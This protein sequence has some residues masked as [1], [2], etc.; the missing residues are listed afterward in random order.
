MKLATALL[1]LASPSLAQQRAAPVLFQEDAAA[2]TAAQTS[3]LA[4]MLRQARPFTLEPAAVRAALATAPLE[5]AAGASGP[6]VVLA[7]PLPDGRTAR[8]ALRQTAVMA[9][10][11][12]ARYPAI[13]TYSGAGLDDATASL[14][15]S[16][17]P[18]GLHAQVLSATAGPVYIDPANLSDATHYLSYAV[19]ERRITA[20]LP[21]CAAPAA[22][23]AGAPLNRPA[24]AA[25]SEPGTAARSSGPQLHVLRLA[26]ATTDEYTAARGNT[27]A[28]ALAG[29]VT[30][31]NRVSG[32]Y[33]RELGIRLE[34]VA[35][36]DQLIAANTPGAPDTFSNNNAIP[37]AW[38]ENQ[39]LLDRIVGTAG[40]DIGHVFGTYGG[41]YAQISS[42]CDPDFKAQG[43]SGLSSPVGDGFDIQFVAHEMGHQLG[44]TH[45]FNADNA[46]SCTAL[47][48]A[49]ST[50][51]EPGS[52]STMMA[53]PGTCGSENLQ[54]SRDAYF[55]GASYAQIQAKLEYDACGRTLPT[56]NSAPVV[57]TGSL[58]KKVPIGTPF[59]LTAYASDA[60]NDALLYNWE[61]MDAGAAVSLTA[62]QTTNARWPLF[63]SYPASSSATRYF[64]RLSTLL[65]NGNDVAERL[66]SVTRTLTF[67]CLVRDLHN[68]TQ[69]VVGGAAQTSG[70]PLSFTAA[71]GPFVVTAP[72]TAVSWP[73]SST[74]TV[75]WNVAGTDANGVDCARVNIRLS[76]DGGLTYPHL[77]LASTPND[78]TQTILVPNVPGP[79]A[80]LLVE[81]ADNVFFD[82]S[83]SSFTITPLP[84]APS[85]S[86]LSP[87][88]GPEGSTI[89]ISGSNLLGVTAVEF[90]G[91][92][93][94]FTNVTATSLTATVPN[95]LT[96]TAAVTVRTPAGLSNS[97]PFTLQPMIASIS[98][99]SGYLATSQLDGTTLTITGSGFF[100]ATGVRFN[101][102][103]FFAYGLTVDATGQHITFELPYVIGQTLPASGTVTVLTP[104]GEITSTFTFTVLRNPC[105]PPRTLTV[106]SITSTSARIGF[107]RSLGDPLA[108][109]LS[110]SP[111]T[112]VDP[113]FEAGEM[114]TGLTPNTTYTVRLVSDCGAGDSSQAVTV[115]F[116]TPPGGFTNDEC[117]G[118][119][120]LVTS[121]P[122]ETCVLTSGQLGTATQSRPPVWCSGTAIATAPDVWYRFVATGP[123]H[124]VTIGGGFNGVLEAFQG[125]CGN[126]VSLECVDF[127]GTG[128]SLTL[129][130]LTPGATYWARYYT[131]TL[132]SATT[133]TACVS[134]PSLGAASCPTSP[135]GLAMSNVLTTS[136][137]L[138]FVPVPGA[139]S[140][141]I[142]FVPRITTRT[143]SA[144]PVSLTG[145]QS[146]TRYVV[147]VS[148]T[149]ADGSVSAPA[150]LAFTT[151]LPDIVVSTSA[152]FAARA[153]R[154]VTITSTGEASPLFANQS[155][156]IWIG[157]TMR[158][159]RGGKYFDN[160]ASIEGPG[161][162][163][164]EPGAT[165]N[166]SHP[167]GIS[168]SGPS[169][170]VQVTGSRTFGNNA[171]FNYNPLV[172]NAPGVTGTG[173]PDTVQTLAFYGPPNSDY[174]LSRSVAVRERLEAYD[175][176]LLLGSANL[177]LLS[178]HRRTAYVLDYNA[179]VRN[180][181]TG[182]A[183]MQRYVSPSTS[184][185]GPGYRHY[186]SPVGGAT[187]ASL[188][189]PGRFVPLVNAAYN[190]QP[191]PSLPTGLFPTVFRYNESRL[192]AAFPGFDDGW[193]SPANLA[194]PLEIGRGYTV[195]IAPGATV[196]LTGELNS[197]SINTGP[198]R[199]GPGPNG[200][201]HL[202]GN[203]YPSPLVIG[204]YQIDSLR[205]GLA[206]AVYVFEP[207][208]QYGGFYRSYV[209]GI[210]T[211]GSGYLILP[212]MQ[213]FF[214]RAL[215]DV[216]EGFTFTPDM[217]AYGK[218]TIAFHRSS[219][220]A[221]PVRPTLR[222]RLS[223]AT[224]SDHAVVYLQPGATTAGTDARF[225]AAKLMN[226][227]D[228][229]QLA[230]LMPG[231]GNEPLAI[232][233]LP[234]LTTRA[235]TRV[236]LTL[237]L[238]AP[239][240]YQLR[241]AELREFD[242]SVPVWL[243]DHARGSRTNL[244]QQPTYGFSATQAGTLNGR[245]ELLL[246]RSG[247]ALATATT[248][249]NSFSV[250]PNPV[251]QGEALR[252]T[253]NEPT[254]A[255]TATL[256]TL[257]GQPV[258]RVSFGGSTGELATAGLAPGTYL[259][260]VQA[261][262][263]A[264]CTRRVVLE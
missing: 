7:L 233:G 2:R 184:Y 34:L 22:M 173:L 111:P 63:R 47:Q 79:T 213:G 169:G 134:T 149:C 97:L 70:L 178:D 89:T 174:T 187:V 165:L 115:R 19:S 158:I 69:G 13:R 94:S 219:P 21:D 157:G 211:D 130:G 110:T 246:G 142:S 131:R 52:G 231:P 215:Q 133:I 17:D 61:E 218:D 116:S 113:D 41:G 262:G 210:T 261:A 15:L 11:L 217:R 214:M 150:L 245:F 194:E 120:L 209:N 201:W 53:Y 51:F 59:R 81:G 242:P 188:T 20:P 1:A 117:P 25:P 125:S 145:L 100:G 8:F 50:P 141:T 156:R 192:T 154:N 147:S 16:L 39:L 204:S 199:A 144:G 107:T 132:N 260:V 28:S 75:T 27:V 42:A 65:A 248:R 171:N 66:P 73:V 167:G 250:W 24:P 32:L 23:A 35:N 160:G 29:V 170:M 162:F 86:S 234:D 225:D 153:Y 18:G 71:A 205:N 4:A 191:V 114:L 223:G 60:E 45:T 216:P 232:N 177:L 212:A 58:S 105:R 175:V 103:Y 253:L 40:Y 127:S 255:A 57:S 26:V 118:A 251:P 135:S 38:L 243:L 193:E 124:T 179:R 55:H 228:A 78:G 5:G 92:S 207:S 139:M 220:V 6:P 33:E 236:P 108:Y 140:Y 48:R 256:T 129:L 176:N 238:A 126:L 254:P 112:I 180:T 235:D 96:S 121:A 258:T 3:P 106:G 197:D 136:A 46:G 196:A 203:P 44:A 229:P 83:N 264:A 31:V 56:G 68:G 241:V 226:P 99:T 161:S 151:P 82:I 98:P 123:V 77:V 163:V 143:V 183:T 237:R 257:L 159:E 87:N 104:S 206:H 85:L 128:E 168:Q 239:G 148:S 138:N 227:G 182:R 185:R 189:L 90:E 84:G 80:R 164:L 12:A 54:G 95:A 263:Q 102:P 181:G 244:R 198:L 230:S 76:T 64:P 9:P 252:L 101:N 259:L 43:Q 202:L 186:S 172:E 30:T 240:P 249:A 166:I 119:I 10:A 62:P 122:G 137:T 72:N 224:G 195:N 93:A 208:S 200:G 74:Q 37:G 247:T 222:L 91:V 146:G 14:R 49:E 67:S 190:A 88:A 221:A 152:S 36:N 155:Y 109:V